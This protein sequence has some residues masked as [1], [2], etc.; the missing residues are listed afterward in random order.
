M[1]IGI[2]RYLKSTDRGERA[3]LARSLRPALAWAPLKLTIGEK[4]LL[5]YCK[6]DA[7]D[8]T[9]DDFVLIQGSS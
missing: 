9:L 2:Y 5:E 6:L 4:H 3:A 8:P 1:D 7:L